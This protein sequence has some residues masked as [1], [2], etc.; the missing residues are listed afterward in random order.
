[1]IGYMFQKKALISICMVQ[2][3]N[4]PSQENKQKLQNKNLSLNI[5]P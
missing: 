4:L 2:K 3:K 5:N 1:M